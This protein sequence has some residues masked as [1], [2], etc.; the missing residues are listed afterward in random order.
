MNPVNFRHR[1]IAHIAKGK[2]LDVGYDD[3][4]NNFLKG[5]VIGVDLITRSHPDNYKRVIVGDAM[6]I[7]T[8]FRLKSFDT[9]IG[10]EIIEHLENPAQFLRASRQV[11]KDTGTL[12]LSAC[13]PYHLPTI[14]ANALFIRPE[15]TA[16]K[17]HDPWHIS[18]LP[19]RSMITLLEHC[20][21]SLIKV[22]NANGLI[23]NPRIDR[24]PWLPFF[25]AFSQSLIYVAEKRFIK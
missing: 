5:E 6:K 2:I 19:Y 13:N 8:I 3:H 21:F 1:K 23:L 12:I 18:L 24:G 15:F 10:A 9:I 14:L 22:L 16:H 11:L 7:D 20:D 4:P 17:T 25:K